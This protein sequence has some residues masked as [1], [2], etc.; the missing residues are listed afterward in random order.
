MLCFALAAKQANE[1]NTNFCCPPVPLQISHRIVIPSIDGRSPVRGRNAFAEELSHFLRRSKRRRRRL[2]S[3]GASKSN[4]TTT[5]EG[6][7]DDDPCEL[8]TLPRE[9]KVFVSGSSFFLLHHVSQQTGNTMSPP[10]SLIR[11]RK[12]V[13]IKTGKYLDYI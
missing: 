10:T 7:H 13:L 9:K 4:P 11:S 6:R 5:A 2:F 8:L 1:A 3:A 12:A